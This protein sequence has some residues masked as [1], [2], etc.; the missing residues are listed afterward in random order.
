M[1]AEHATDTHDVIRYNSTA[2]NLYRKKN[3]H[4]SLT[5]IQPVSRLLYTQRSV[6]EETECLFV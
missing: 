5:Q 3:N 1:T 6:F 4:R 2:Q